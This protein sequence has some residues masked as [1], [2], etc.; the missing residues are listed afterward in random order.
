MESNTTWDV[1]FQEW[2]CERGPAGEAAGEHGECVNP[3]GAILPG[4]RFLLVEMPDG[5]LRRYH[6][7]CVPASLRDEG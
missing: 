3:R 2:K 1:A 4:D 5:R 7:A 6:E